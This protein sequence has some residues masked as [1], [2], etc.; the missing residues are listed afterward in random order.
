MNW[1]GERGL[2]GSRVYL[3]G[4]V[5]VEVVQ[6][7]LTTFQADAIVSAANERLNLYGGLAKAIADA[8]IVYIYI[9]ENLAYLIFTNC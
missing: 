7:N 8:G 3:P 9:E 5:S 6:G 2:V 1:S 4:G